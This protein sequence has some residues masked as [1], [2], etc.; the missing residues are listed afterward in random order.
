MT[1]NSARRWHIHPHDS[2]S[3]AS[4]ARSINVP[5]L[6]AVLLSVRGLD[7]PDAARIF[8]DAPLNG[9]HDPSLLPGAAEAADRILHAIQHKKILLSMVITMRMESVEPASSGMPCV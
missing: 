2:D 8:L 4:F 3:I 5:P 1:A 6:V 9:M 7:H